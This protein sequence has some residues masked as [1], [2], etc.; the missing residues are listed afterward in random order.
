MSTHIATIKD[1]KVGEH[2]QMMID[3]GCTAIVI[4]QEQY[5][6]SLYTIVS[7]K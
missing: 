4:T 5:R 7:H 2:V 6:P 3:S 1:E